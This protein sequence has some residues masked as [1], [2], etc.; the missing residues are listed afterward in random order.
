MIKRK[1]IPVP[2]SSMSESREPRTSEN[3]LLEAIKSLR[4]TVSALNQTLQAD[5]PKR[6]EI[7][8]DR[9]TFTAW[10]VIG[11]LLSAVGGSL[12]TIGT[13]SGCFL[14]KSAAD[15]NVPAFCSALPGYSD[16]RARNART[17]DRFE[18]LILEIQQNS[19]RLDALENKQ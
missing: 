6:E 7:K 14:S 4:D 1:E 19:K 12:V 11:L 5:Y 15:G 8:R 18:Q 2:E 9:K 3:I 17:R 10:I 16:A 13:V